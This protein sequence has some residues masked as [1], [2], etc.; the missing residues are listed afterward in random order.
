MYYPAEFWRENRKTTV[1][2][3]YR[4]KGGTYIPAKTAMNIDYLTTN[5]NLGE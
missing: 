2:I 3:Q 1:K 5:N 4:R